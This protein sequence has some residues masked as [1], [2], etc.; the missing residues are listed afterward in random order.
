RFTVF[1]AQTPG[2]QRSLDRLIAAF[3]AAT[4][5]WAGETLPESGEP[6]PASGEPRTGPRS[7]TN[8]G[9]SIP[10]RPSLRGTTR[11]PRAAHTSTEL[12]DQIVQRSWATGNLLIR[13][14][15]GPDL[16]PEMESAIR[17]RMERQPPEDFT[18]VF[19]PFATLS[20]RS[21]VEVLS[22]Y[23]SRHS[24]QPQ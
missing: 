23:L 11:R 21:L 5:E 17:Q 6:G 1:A 20:A 8:S 14:K 2:R 16:D 13:P 22:E 15:N 18:V 4:V 9:A 7:R 3:P 10:R 12:G 19:V 24:I